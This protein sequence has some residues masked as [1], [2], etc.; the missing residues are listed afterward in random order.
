[1]N[2]TL[3]ATERLFS[4]KILKQTEINVNGAREKI[5]EME[6]M[7]ADVI[8][9]AP[10]TVTLILFTGND[11]LNYEPGHFLTISPHQFPALERWVSY[12][13]DQKGKKEPPRAYSLTSSP[14]E[15]Y[16]AITVK[17]ERYIS[18]VTPFP[19]LLSPIL[20]RRTFAGQKMIITGFTG[21]FTFN[22]QIRRES[23]N[24]LHV[25]AGSGIVPTYSII[26]Y[27][28]R[29]FSK[30]RHTLIYSNKK[31]EDIIFFNQLKQLEEEFPARLKVIH[32]L[33]RESNE[34]LFNPRIRKGRVSKEFIS[35]SIED[36]SS[37][38]VFVCGP[39]HTIHQ[40][41]A[42]KEKGEELKPSFMESVLSSL[43]EIG[44]PKNKIKK[45]SY[46]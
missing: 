8:Q 42:A 46:G 44:I 24:V 43:E 5:K 36:L 31:F 19:P 35:E 13:E 10:D 11:K 32:T 15:K 25:C 30:H 3:L 23:E 38:G 9:E 45:E 1:M 33:T 6:V 17:E 18:G 27:D 26:K 20:A 16:L 21:P 37:L 34:S 28:L 41:K 14:D 29:Y 7:V 22:E 2:V 4:Y 40:K 12:L 39:D